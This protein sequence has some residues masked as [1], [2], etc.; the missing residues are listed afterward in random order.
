ME[1]YAY[2][3]FRLI[4]V[5]SRKTLSRVLGVNNLRD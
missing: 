1:F 2:R 5:Y 4:F 3:L